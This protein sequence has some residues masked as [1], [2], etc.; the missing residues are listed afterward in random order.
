[1]GVITDLHKSFSINNRH[2]TAVEANLDNL[3]T[4]RNHALRLCTGVFRKSPIT[5]IF[6]EVGTIALQEK[7]NRLTLKHYLKVAEN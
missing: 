6:E 1:M 4:I 2:D 3:N 5:K 7:R